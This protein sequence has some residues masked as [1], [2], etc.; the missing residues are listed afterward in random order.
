[1]ERKPILRISRWRDS[2]LACLVYALMTL[3]VITVDGIAPLLHYG[4]IVLVVGIGLLIV[5]YFLLW[6][7]DVTNESVALC[8]F[9]RKKREYWFEEFSGY[10]FGGIFASKSFD[11]FVDGQ[12]VIH[13]LYTGH[14]RSSAKLSEL[15]RIVEQKRIRRFFTGKDKVLRARPE[16][17][18]LPACPSSMFDFGLML[19]LSSVGFIFILVG[20]FLVNHPTPVQI[21]GWGLSFPLTAL[22]AYFA[23]KHHKFL[24]FS[25]TISSDGIIINEFKKS[26]RHIYY[27]EISGV[28]LQNVYYG[29]SHSNI[30][31]YGDSGL[32]VKFDKGIRG[33]SALIYKLREL[34]IPFRYYAA[35]PGGTNSEMLERGF[36]YY[37]APKKQRAKS[38]RP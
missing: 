4:L 21:W 2:I 6:H 22:F 28:V 16:G 38:R 18:T 32:L 25:V 34:G 11:F 35:G 10:D 23:V 14:W 31:I 5:L 8:R 33:T 29:N 7:V 19:L 9:L 20:P 30:K 36:M 24:I 12:R 37:Y 15:H 17:V 26:C 27:E 13:L 3:F 1:M